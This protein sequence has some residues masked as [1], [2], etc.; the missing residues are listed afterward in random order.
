MACWNDN[1]LFTVYI[2]S[3]VEQVYCNFSAL[4]TTKAPHNWALTDN[5][6]LDSLG[7]QLPTNKQYFWALQTNDW[8]PQ[9]YN[10]SWL[11]SILKQTGQLTIMLKHICQSMYVGVNEQAYLCNHAPFLSGMKLPVV[12]FLPVVIP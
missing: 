9:C 3:L 7:V 8:R 4:Q 2:E 6:G 10:Y 5:T 12:A 11:I 1:S